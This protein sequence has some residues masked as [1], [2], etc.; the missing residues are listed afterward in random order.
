M[1]GN[2][3]SKSPKER[4]R[5]GKHARHDGD[6]M[7]LPAPRSIPHRFSLRY[8][9]EKMAQ[10]QANLAFRNN[11]IQAS[12]RANYHNEIDR[13]HSMLSSTILPTA[14]REML[15]HRRNQIKK[16]AAEGVNNGFFR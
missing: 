16:L 1:L 9:M 6:D 4:K 14:S 7:I 8:L 5:R 11:A 12:N 15:E 2:P 13:I 10:K 3:R